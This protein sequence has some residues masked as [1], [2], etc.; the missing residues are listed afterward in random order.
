MGMAKRRRRRKVLAALDLPLETERSVVKATLLARGDL[1]IETHNGILE[2][3][4]EQIR[5]LTPQG[6]LCVQ[7]ANLTMEQLNQ[8][9]VY[10]CGKI[11]A[12]SF[13]GGT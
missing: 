6:I 4:C 12:Q 13:E 9:Q 3:T 11:T 5:L 10:I 7:G 8:D 2:Y 1:L